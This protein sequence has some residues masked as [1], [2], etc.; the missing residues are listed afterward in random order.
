MTNF[1]ILMVM[2]VLTSLILSSCNRHIV[3]HKE[4]PQY[5]YNCPMHTNYISD[6]PGKCPKCGMTLEQMELDKLRIKN[7][8]S[9]HSGYSSSGGHSGGHH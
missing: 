3:K 8:G 1:K 2:F 5:Y 6:E 9:P 4:K 7:A